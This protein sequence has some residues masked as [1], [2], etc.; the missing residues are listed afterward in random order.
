MKKIF[1]CLFSIPS[2][3]IIAAIIISFH[4]VWINRYEFIPIGEKG[5]HVINKWTGKTCIYSISDKLTD[6]R[7]DDY[8]PDLCNWDVYEDGDI[9]RRLIFLP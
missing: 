5:F 2:A 7:L 3:I 9:E 4:Y 8:T 1:S 6:Y